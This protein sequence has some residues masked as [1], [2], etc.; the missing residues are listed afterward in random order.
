M[1]VEDKD[2]I[3]ANLEVECINLPEYHDACD[4]FQVETIESLQNSY[5]GAII[6]RQ[7]LNYT[8]QQKHQFLLKATVF[9]SNE[10]LGA[11]SNPCRFFAGRPTQQQ[12]KRDRKHR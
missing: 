12:Y 7:K 1:L 4:F 2:T 6:L 3:G 9:I 11:N 10:N 5:H 8:A